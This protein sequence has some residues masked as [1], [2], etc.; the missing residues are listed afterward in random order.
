MTNTVNGFGL[1]RLLCTVA[2]C[3]VCCF[4]GRLSN[5][6]TLGERGASQS[7]DGAVM[8]KEEENHRVSLFSKL[9]T[10]SHRN[11]QQFYEL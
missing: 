11:F 5:R 3:F 6:I 2:S 1:Y 10:C 9:S 7:D 8:R 4:V